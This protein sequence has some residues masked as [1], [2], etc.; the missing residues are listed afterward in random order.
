MQQKPMDSSA[1]S[2]KKIPFVW[3]QQAQESFEELKQAL[4]SAPLLL[5]QDFTQGFI[6]YLSALG[7]A[8]AGVLVQED[9]VH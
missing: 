5:P 4:A 2:A 7:N 8:I 3:D 1:C 6:I 9:D